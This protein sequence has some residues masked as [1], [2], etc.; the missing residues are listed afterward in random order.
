[1]DDPTAF[2]K[3]VAATVARERLWPTGARILAACSGGPDS[4]ALLGWLI[5]EMRRGQVQAG[6]VY[7]H[8]H[9]RAAADA[10]AAYVER[11]GREQGVPVYIRHVDVPK[12][13]KETGE[14]TETAARVLRYRALTAV[15]EAEGYAYIA[16]AH[17]ADDQAETVLHHLLR[18]TGPRGLRGML[19]RSGRIVR[20]LLGVTRA[21][22]DAYLA[23][24]CPYLPCTD[25]TNTDTAYLRNALRHDVLPYL[26][27]YNPNLRAGLCRLAAIMREETDWADTL[28]DSWWREHATVT[29]AGVSLPRPAVWHTALCRHVVRRVYTDCVQA[30][31]DARQTETIVT[32]WR[33]GRT[34]ARYAARGLYWEV[35][36]HRLT[37]RRQPVAPR[38]DIAS[39]A[40]GETDTLVLGPVR[41]R[42]RRS[43]EP[44][45][46][47]NIPVA[48]VCG[49]LCLR[50]RRPGDRIVLPRVGTQKW[51]DWLINHKVPRGERDGIILL[52][53][54][55]RIY[56]AF[57]YWQGVSV[58][59][60]PGPYWAIGDR[61]RMQDEGTD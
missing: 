35:E 10:E 42:V 40:A 31:P 45:G 17:H 13:R 4:L 21:E 48:A 47:I 2:E 29:A 55:R 3:K 22:I 24:Y 12:R 23:A 36:A 43:D 32:L 58:P 50:T 27:Q 26:A 25:E 56:C 16:V 53:D 30:T 54:D 38:C 6:V 18:G 7:V 19:P 15:A 34:G 60:E 28:T 61:R 41:V 59:D 33:E 39:A 46:A 11:I 51:K 14:S 57:G 37:A 44:D 52:A 9:L 8:H 49:R 20:P 5:A 1:M